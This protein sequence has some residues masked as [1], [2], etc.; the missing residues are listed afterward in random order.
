MSEFW[1][2]V[3]EL[4]AMRKWIPEERRALSGVREALRCDVLSKVTL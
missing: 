3:R 1:R 2:A 4:A